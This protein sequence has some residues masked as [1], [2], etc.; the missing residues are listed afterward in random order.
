[1]KLF[2]LELETKKYI[3]QAKNYASK[4]RVTLTSIAILLV[5][6]TAIIRIDRLASPDMNQDRYDEQL[7]TIQRVDFDED[8]IKEIRALRDVDVDVDSRFND[9]RE[10][11]FSE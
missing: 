2:G 4:Y 3:T 9:R 7:E 1:M 8:A 10:N 6:S 5:F 11:P